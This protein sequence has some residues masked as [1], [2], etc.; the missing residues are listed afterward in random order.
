MAQIEGEV[1]EEQR[2]E[3]RLIGQ[4]H[5]AHAGSTLAR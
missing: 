4:E 5:D 2:Q 1:E 3:E